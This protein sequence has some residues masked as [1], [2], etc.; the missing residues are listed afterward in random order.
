MQ[1]RS[2]FIAGTDTGIGKTWIAQRLIRAMVAQGFRVAAMKPIAAGADLTAD[3]LRNEDALA[4]MQASNVE[5]PYALVNPVCLPL[6]TSPHLA[7]R[8]AGVRID[9]QAVRVA[10][11]ALVHRA[12]VVV[13]EG[14]GGWLAPIGDGPDETMQDIAMA[15]GLPVVLVVGLRLGCISHALLTQDAI[16]RS[17]LEFSGWIAN[18]GFAGADP[19]FDRDGEYLRALEERLLAPQITL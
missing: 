16:L 14:A 6:A 12:D 11:D 19:D 5:A 8:A 10:Y 3:G 1:A 7:A 2:A 17:G 9:P 13:A 4:L 18:A 15:L